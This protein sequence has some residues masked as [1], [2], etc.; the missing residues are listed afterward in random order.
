MDDTPR[1]RGTEDHFLAV[2]PWR[3]VYA[4]MTDGSHESSQTILKASVPLC[5]GVSDPP[6]N[7]SFSRLGKP[8]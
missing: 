6:S 2:V 1:H 5:L 8:R 3:D 4:S 7:Y